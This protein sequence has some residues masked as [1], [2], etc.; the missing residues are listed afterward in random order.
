MLKLIDII[1]KQEQIKCWRRQMSLTPQIVP[2]RMASCNITTR[3]AFYCLEDSSLHVYFEDSGWT[4][5]NV[6]EERYQ[7]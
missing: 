5:I 4:V 1:K 6:G 7:D 2:W 3:D